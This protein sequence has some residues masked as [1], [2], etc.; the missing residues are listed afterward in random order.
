MACLSAVSSSTQMKQ[1]AKQLYFRTSS[2]L[3]GG[4]KFDQS[5]K[6]MELFLLEALRILEKN[7][8][9]LDVYGKMVRD[10]HSYHTSYH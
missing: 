3:N 6:T 5:I 7:V 10:A 4:S 2:Y 8:R 9:T 1:R